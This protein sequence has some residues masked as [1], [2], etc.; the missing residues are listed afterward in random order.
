MNAR[1]QKK[2]PRTT[3]QRLMDKVVIDPVTGCWMWNGAQRH[4]YGVMRHEGK[5]KSVHRVAYI[6]AHG[7]IPDGKCVCHACD[8][9]LCV[10]PDHLVLG[11]H[12]E[13]QRQKKERGRAGGGR[14][15]NAREREVVAKADLPV[16]TLMRWT[17]LTRQGIQYLRRAYR[18][19]A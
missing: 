17:G 13:N 1:A 12:A 11:D 9:P 10:H 16:S 7:P 5:V 8:T 2:T 14:R 19:A 4:G 15:L 18:R 3:L 6:L